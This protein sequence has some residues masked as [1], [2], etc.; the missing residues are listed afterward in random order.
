MSR[1]AASWILVLAAACGGGK[2]SATTTPAP[3]EVADPIPKTAGPACDV[4]ADK[5]SIVVEAENPDNQP[6]A[7]ASIDE[8]CKKDKWSDEARSCFA[9]VEN[10]DEVGGC[11]KMLTDDQRGKWGGDDAAKAT[12]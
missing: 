7:K 4:V 9:T 1:F 8:H 6:A 12:P 11:K 10:D 3:K 2:S 5:L